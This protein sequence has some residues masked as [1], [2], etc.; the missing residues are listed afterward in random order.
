MQA[1]ES[2]AAS[3]GTSRSTRSGWCWQSSILGLVLKAVTKRL[4]STPILPES[5]RR[6]RFCDSLLELLIAAN[7][8]RKRRTSARQFALQ[9]SSETKPNIGLHSLHAAH[10]AL[11]LIAFS[12]AK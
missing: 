4:D 8:G 5:V 7:S 11:P 1:I 3:G 6:S 10:T 2:R 9:R 12:V